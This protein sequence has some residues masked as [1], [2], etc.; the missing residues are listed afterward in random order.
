MNNGFE[1]TEEAIKQRGEVFTPTG[2]VSEML[3]KLP[4]ALFKSKDKTFLDYG[5]SLTA[6]KK[7]KS[8]RIPATKA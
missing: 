4:P 7:L 8:Y 3:N 6:L 5:L 1:H 2:L